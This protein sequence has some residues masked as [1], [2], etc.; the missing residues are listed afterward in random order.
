MATGHAGAAELAS[1]RLRYVQSD[2]AFHNLSFGCSPLQPGAPHEWDARSAPAVMQ[3][4]PA[5]HGGVPGGGPCAAP[6]I[7]APPRLGGWQRCGSYPGCM[8]QE[9]PGGIPRVGTYP[10]HFLV[11]LDGEDAHLPGEGLT[12]SAVG[13]ERAAGELGAPSDGQSGDSAASIGHGGAAPAGPCPHEDCDS[14]RTNKGVATLQCRVCARKWR[15]RSDE[16]DKCWKFWFLDCCRKR[17]DGCPKLHLHKYGV[18][19]G[20]QPDELAGGYRRMYMALRYA[21]YCVLHGTLRPSDLSAMFVAGRVSLDWVRELRPCTPMFYACEGWR[22]AR[23][24]S[25]AWAGVPCAHNNWEK[26]KG[27]RC[28]GRTLLQCRVCGEPW[29]TQTNMLATS[30]E[31]SKCRDFFLFY[32]CPRGVACDYVHVHRERKEHERSIVAKIVHACASEEADLH[33]QAQVRLEA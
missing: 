7:A 29:W 30:P 21:R 15:Q 22:P 27:K 10:F 18:K 1:P 20:E 33:E 26:N 9:G 8:E 6:A 16:M 2:A 25:E 13:S 5:H 32:H 19:R 28:K 31:G 12:D 11:D 3:L 17:H 14:I 23:E 4:H 24:S